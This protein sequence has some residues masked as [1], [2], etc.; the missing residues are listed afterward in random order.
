MS[1]EGHKMLTIK[2][3]KLESLKL[4]NSFHQKTSLWKWK[5][6]IQ[7]GLKNCEK[8]SGED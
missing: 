7:S 6:K 2:K 4:R 1:Y 3:N 5:G 8:F